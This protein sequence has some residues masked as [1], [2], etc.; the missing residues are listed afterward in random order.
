MT[1]DLFQ[2]LAEQAELTIVSSIPLDWGGEAALDRL[3]LLAKPE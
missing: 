3:S 2:S 1:Y